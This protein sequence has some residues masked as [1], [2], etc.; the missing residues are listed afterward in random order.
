[1]IEDWIDAVTKVW[2]IPDMKAGTVTSY[3]VFERNEFPEE[4][5]LDRA[6]A[7]TFCDV[8]DA[9]YSMGGPNKAFWHGTTFFHLTPD[10]ARA[11][12]PYVLRFY[13][14]IILAAAANMR[15]SGLV[16]YFAL[17][18]TDSISIVQLSYG[19][20]APHMGLE[21]KWTVK[22]QMTGLVIG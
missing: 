22:E 5:P 21:V 12:V 17:E 15:L 8:V 19:N 1:M 14:P 2:E 4:V 7:L 10:L 20:E 16:D 13:K 11:R 9:E 6:V 18:P 3:R